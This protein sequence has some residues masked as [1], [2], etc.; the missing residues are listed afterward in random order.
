MEEG[1]EGKPLFIF[2][3]QNGKGDNTRSKFSMDLRESLEQGVHHQIRV[4]QVY[5]ESSFLSIVK[6]RDPHFIMSVMHEPQELST[7]GVEKPDIQGNATSHTTPR[8]IL[9]AP[10]NSPAVV[11][12]YGWGIW[13]KVLVYF[14]SARIVKSGDIA[15]MVNRVLRDHKLDKF[16]KFGVNEEGK[17]EVTCNELLWLGIREDFNKTLGFDNTAQ[18][19]NVKYLWDRHV[20]LGD[21]S[22]GGDLNYCVYRKTYALGKIIAV[23]HFNANSYIPSTFSIH[24]REMDYTIN[25]SQNDKV[26]VIC[27]SPMNND[28][29]IYTFCPLNRVPHQFNGDVI[30]EMNFT[31]VNGENGEQ[32]AFSNGSATYMECMISKMVYTKDIKHITCFS[33][34]RESLRLSPLN[35]SSSFTIHLS[36][37]VS[38]YPYKKW[39]LQLINVSL[40]CRI[41][42]ITSRNAHIKV[43]DGVQSVTVNFRAGYYESVFKLVENINSNIYTQAKDFGIVFSALQDYVGVSNVGKIDL[44]LTMTSTLALILGCRDVD[45]GREMVT[46]K[47]G[48]MSTMSLSYNHDIN[49]GRPRYLKVLCEQVEKSLM[50]DE[51]EGILSFSAID[52]PSAN[53]GKILFFDFLN[54]MKIDIDG[55]NLSRLDFTLSSGISDEPLEFDEGD[56]QGTHLSLVLTRGG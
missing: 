19:Y 39:G 51:Q 9:T 37:P 22:A 33:D 53:N 1:K 3:N 48:E 35:K 36:S 31:L 10:S 5:I 11:E 25:G 52:S 8:V 23:N 4:N 41:R 16:I 7:K 34:D 56:R 2:S 27:P 46:L 18:I 12:Y 44:N 45:V 42:N 30:S 26:M 29:R 43:D 40:S 15:S 24:L 47:V 38:K 14:K 32:L 49:M 28:G 21:V 50:G 20:G 13:K 54:P 6:N 55:D 17:F